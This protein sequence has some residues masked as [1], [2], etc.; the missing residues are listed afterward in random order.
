[1]T[2]TRTVLSA[3]AGSALALALAWAG[4]SAAAGDPVADRQALMKGV[5]QSMKDASGFATGQTPWDAA[6]VKAVTG[7]IAASGKKAQGLFPASSATHAKSQADARVWQ[8]K[9][10]FDK[11]LAEMSALATAAGKTTSMEAYRPAFQKLS[12]TCKS[13]HDLYRKKKT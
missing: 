6:K 1:M 2:R 13:C 8:N 11:R 3:A 7:A 10:D 12:A 9:A 4:A 5:G